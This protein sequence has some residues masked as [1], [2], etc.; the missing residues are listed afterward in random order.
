M[1]FPGRR[2]KY[3]LPFFIIM[4]PLIYTQCGGSFVANP[5]ASS[6]SQSLSST[7]CALISNNLADLKT[8]QDAVALINALPKPLSIDCFLANLKLPLKVFA[9]NNSFSAQPSVGADSPRIFIISNNLILSVVPAG[10]GKNMVEFSQITRAG[11]SIKA[12]IHFPVSA[13]LPGDTPYAQILNGSYGTTCMSCHRNETR[14]TTISV[15]EAYESEII[16]PSP[17]QR[18]SQTYLLNQAKECNSRIDDFRCRLLKTIFIR[19]QAVDVDF[20][21]GAN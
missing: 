7:S 6:N 1:G 19:G 20:P 9:V 10:E 4:L 12:E 11:Y 17:F 8:V 5:N 16:M 18:V 15:G 13:G 3:I 21:Q 14:A 2:A